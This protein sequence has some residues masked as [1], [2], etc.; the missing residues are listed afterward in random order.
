MIELPLT[1]HWMAISMMKYKRIKSFLNGELK[2]RDRL[3]INTKILRAF[4]YCH[5]REET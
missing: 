2:K 5:S 4:C 3:K 1:S